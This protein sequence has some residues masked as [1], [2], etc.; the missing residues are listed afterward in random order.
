MI[1]KPSSPSFSS[2]NLPNTDP[3]DGVAYTDIVE[4][5]IDYEK[6]VSKLMYIKSTLSFLTFLKFNRWK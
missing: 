1:L 6:E 5:S 4:G 2:T 3:F